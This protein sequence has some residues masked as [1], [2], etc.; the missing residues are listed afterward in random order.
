MAIELN[1]ISTAFR[2]KIHVG[3]VSELFSHIYV[4]ALKIIEGK[5]VKSPSS[6]RNDEL[7]T[8][9]EAKGST[10]PRP[11]IASAFSA[12][13]PENRVFVLGDGKNTTYSAGPKRRSS[14]SD[15][16]NGPL[17]GAT[18]YSIFQRIFVDNKVS[19]DIYLVT[20]F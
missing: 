10:E 1:C 15:Y 7:V 4:I 6:Y 19:A 18:S 14:S 20:I 2:L 17:E 3:I 8:Y 12:S 9:A 5:Q 11:Y 16:Y 13:R